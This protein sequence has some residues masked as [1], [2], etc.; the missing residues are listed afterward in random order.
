MLMPDST[1][2]PTSASASCW[3]VFQVCPIGRLEPVPSPKLVTPYHIR[4]TIKPE[5]PRRVYCMNSPPDAIAHQTQN[6]LKKIQKQQRID[7]VLFSSNTVSF[8]IWGSVFFR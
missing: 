5:L 6:L 1:A 8:G 4:E 7:G 2:R 3:G